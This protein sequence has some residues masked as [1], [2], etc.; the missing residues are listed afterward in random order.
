[1]LRLWGGLILAI[2]TGPASY[3]HHTLAA[4]WVKAG[5]HSIEGMLC[6]GLH[7]IPVTEE[8]HLFQIA[9]VPWVEPWDRA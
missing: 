1:M 4:G 9:G 5:Y 6:R 7:K 8:R 2:R 3:S